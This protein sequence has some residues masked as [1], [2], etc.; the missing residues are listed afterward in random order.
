MTHIPGKLG[1]IGNANKDEGIHSQ[2]VLR[3]SYYFRY[4]TVKHPAI[5]EE[6]GGVI[7]DKKNRKLSGILLSLIPVTSLNAAPAVSGCDSVC[8]L[9]AF[10][11][12]RW[13]RGPPKPACGNLV[14]YKGL[15]P[16]GP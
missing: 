1:E 9:P 2:C 11:L 12:A 4:A 15:L 14:Y 5:M 16:A 13:S 8:F 6:Y 3:V 10:I 7:S